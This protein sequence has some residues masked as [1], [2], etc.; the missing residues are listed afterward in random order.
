M[1]PG[2]VIGSA[3]SPKPSNVLTDNAGFPDFNA[4][5][6]PPVQE[7]N[8]I[9]PRAIPKSIHAALPAVGRGRSIAI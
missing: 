1:V 7:R 9:T 3:D 8:V 6:S 4:I 2:K 5:A